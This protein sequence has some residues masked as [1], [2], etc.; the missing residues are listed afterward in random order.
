MSWVQQF[1]IWPLTSVGPAD[2]KLRPGYS[3]LLLSFSS[4]RLKEYLGRQRRVSQSRLQSHLISMPMTPPCGQQRRRINM[5]DTQFHIRCFAPKCR[6]DSSSHLWSCLWSGS[7]DLPTLR[8][9]FPHRWKVKE[10]NW[11]KFVVEKLP[12][13]GFHVCVFHFHSTR[14]V[15]GDD[16]W[17]QESSGEIKPTEKEQIIWCRHSSLKLS[18][19]SF[20]RAIKHMNSR[21]VLTSMAK[22]ENFSPAS[23]TMSPNLKMGHSESFPLWQLLR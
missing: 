7:V 20:D 22:S 11:R 9:H 10:G 3:V 23:R 8:L 15:A 4:R 19:R 14:S 13:F 17:K 5:T 21:V 18:A 16:N 12:T 1:N 2:L 6:L